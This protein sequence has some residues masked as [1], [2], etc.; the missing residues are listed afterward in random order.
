MG[1]EGR[2]VRAEAVVGKGE[3]EGALRKLLQDG[4]PVQ[5]LYQIPPAPFSWTCHT[6]NTYIWRSILDLSPNIHPK[7]AWPA[8]GVTGVKPIPNG[9]P[10]P[11]PPYTKGKRI[12]KCARPPLG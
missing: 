12:P 4:R 11:F 5:L 1:S 7:R 6:R 3:G 10:A 8:P 2:G 9:R